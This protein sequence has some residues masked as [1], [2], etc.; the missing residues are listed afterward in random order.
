MKILQV[1]TV[2]GYGSTGMIAKELHDTC[3]GEG[4][5]CLSA[6][7]CVSKGQE[8]LA[9]SIAISSPVDMRIHGAL[10]R[11][12]MHKGLF[13]FFKTRAFIKKAK[14]Y[15]P[16]IIHLHNLHGSYINL[17][18]L[19]KYIKSENIPVVW[20][21]HDCWAFTG[22]CAHFSAAGCDRWTYGC[23][24]CPQRKKL[25][26][27]P[28][29]LSARMYSLKKKWFTGVQRLTVVTPS[30]WLSELVRGSFL[31]EY[32]VECIYNG[33]DL[34]VFRPSRSDF[35]ERYGLADKKI[36]LG[37]AFGWSYEKGLDVFTE[38]ACRLPKDYAI[39][40]VGTDDSVDR[41][42]PPRIISIHRTDNTA[43]LASVYTAADVFVNPTR[44]EVLGLVNIE[45]LACG[46]PVVT[47]KAGGSP[48][49]IDGSCGVA[50]DIDDVD[51]IEKEILRICTDAPYSVDDCVKRAR[52]FDKKKMLMEYIDLYKS[53]NA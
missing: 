40:L 6:H 12:T 16:D 42:L 37:V 2:Y 1:N 53:K 14:K 9:D 18:L 48:E 23:G 52:I 20:T 39:V 50:V 41:S 46:T 43:E 5:K 33:V 32:S 36:V 47:F 11:F 26:S 4:I 29:D 13:S 31:K 27:C 10:S 17:P 3:V 8:A 35:R 24:D 49:C 45:A 15:R 30:R 38:L 19:F 22:I 44:E 34:D 25:S 51:G 7:R 28:F 21:L